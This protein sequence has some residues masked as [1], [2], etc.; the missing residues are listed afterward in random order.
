MATVRRSGSHAAPRSLLLL[1]TLA[2][3]QGCDTSCEAACDK[4]L[5]CEEVSTAR[6]APD[7]CE[8]ACLVQEKLY[9]DWDD[10]E[11]RDG[12]TE[13]KGCITGT[14]CDELAEGACYEDELY[15]F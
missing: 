14:A 4:L 2:L 11:L 8:S 5:S 13:L 15:P 3:G 7:D 1:A 12:F 9:E 10:V 6:L